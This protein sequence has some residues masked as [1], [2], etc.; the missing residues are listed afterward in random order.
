MNVY[1]VFIFVL[2]KLS[3]GIVLVHNLKWQSSLV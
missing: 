3:M 1:V 2:V